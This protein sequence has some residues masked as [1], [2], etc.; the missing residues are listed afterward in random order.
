M[1][2][3][4]IEWVFRSEAEHVPSKSVDTDFAGSLSF[5][6][7]SSCDVRSSAM[8][9]EV[10]TPAN[11]L[12]ILRMIFI[13]VFVILLVYDHLGWAF[14]IFILA[15]V[16]DG[17]D[18]LIARSSRQKTSLGAYLDPIADKL[19]LITSFVVL[20][21]RGMGLPNLVPLWLTILVISRDIIMISSVLIIVISTG[22][23]KFPPSIYGKTTTFL[24]ISTIVVVLY[25]NYRNIQH[26]ALYW[27][28]VATAVVT[29]YSGLD[30]VYRGKKLVSESSASGN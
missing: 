24:Q 21:I 23:R 11:Q 15:G 30:Y 18:G 9:L 26:E 6:A 13:P 5:K 3:C 25:L 4:Q 2:G 12:T 17:L 20:S 10:L 19:L 29:V 28:F 22:H 7:F 27:L 14:A 1:P 16:T 8:S